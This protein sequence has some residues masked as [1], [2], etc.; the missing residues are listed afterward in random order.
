MESGE[1][2]FAPCLTAWCF[3]QVFTYLSVYGFVGELRHQSCQRTMGDNIIEIAP[4]S[5][6]VLSYTHACMVCFV[7]ETVL[8][9]R[10]G[11]PIKG[12]AEPKNMRGLLVQTV[13][14]LRSSCL[15]FLGVRSPGM[16]CHLLQMLLFE[17]SSCAW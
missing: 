17:N 9:W 11:S 6:G 7:Y 5:V 2:R 1:L 4:G 15:C 8:S 12:Y 3:E 14:K 10:D 16:C 13:L